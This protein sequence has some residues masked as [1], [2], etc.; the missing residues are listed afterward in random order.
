M[1]DP[2]R[3]LPYADDVETIP[4]DEADDIQQ[5][6]QALE[7]ILARSQRKSGQFRADVHVKTH[8][9]AQGEL[10]VLPNLP[11]ELAQGL[12]G[13]DGVYPAVARFSNAASQA[14]FDAVPDGRGMAIKVLGVEGDVV[15]ADEQRGPGQDFVMINHPV[16]FARNV[17]DIPWEVSTASAAGPTPSRATGVVNRRTPRFALIPS[18]L[19]LER[20]DEPSI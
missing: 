20:N 5:V 11:D 9:C 17:K 7:L 15:L 12:F 19:T 14:Q 16:F 4:A 10:R 18:T 6:I 2:N 8:D 13:H 3:P 1:P